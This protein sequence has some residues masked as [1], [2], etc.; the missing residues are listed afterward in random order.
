MTPTTIR[1]ARHG[2][3]EAILSVVARAFSDDSRDAR[4]ELAIV[5]RTWARCPPPSLIELVAD[6]AGAVVGHVQAAPGRLDGRAAVVAGVAPVCV[7]PAHQG[8]GTGSALV[9]A[10]IAEAATRDWPALVLLGD[11][12]FYGRFGFQPAA[13][14]GLTYAPVRADDPHFQAYLLGRDTAVRPGV[15]SYCWEG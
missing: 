10:V 8:R 2:D 9:R 14:L 6:D 13:P 5:R 7:A 4:E 12:A 1:P 3:T 15:F 11:P